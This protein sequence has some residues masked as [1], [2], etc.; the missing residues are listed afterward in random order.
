ML[1]AHKRHLMLD[2]ADIVAPCL[3]MGAAANPFGV[4]AQ[5]RGK[6]HRMCQCGT[7]QHGRD[8]TVLRDL[9]PFQL[10]AWHL[11][12]GCTLG[13][14]VALPLE[15]GYSM[16]KSISGWLGLAVLAGWSLMGCAG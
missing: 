12:M 2:E 5:P 16:K 13:A 1:D 9:T 11:L 8:F 3:I 10:L 4:G 6:W 14:Y 15:K 7:V